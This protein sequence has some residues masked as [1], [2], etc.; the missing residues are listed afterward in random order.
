MSQA[1]SREI[2]TPIGFIS[3]PHLA[4]PDA[5]EDDA[6][7]AKYRCSL[8]IVSEEDRTAR[9][10]VK[11]SIMPAVKQAAIDK[12]GADVD[13]TKLRLP[14]GP[15]N[16]RTAEAYGED[17]IAIAASNKLQPALFNEFG[18][19][20]DGADAKT[21]SQSMYPGAEARFRV[22]AFGYKFG[23]KGVS[24][25]LTGVQYCGGGEPIGTSAQPVS[26][27]PVAERPPSA[28]QGAP[29]PQ[30]GNDA[31]DDNDGMPF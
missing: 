3:Y 24:L 8:I 2:D 25:L 27:A 22:W 18:D 14:V 16:E 15:V 23:K 30:A 20:L 26:M 4:K 11:A 10:I 17:A 5:F 19:E 1:P 28:K 6:D 12:F 9:E 13:L 21:F 7:S 29:M 31:D